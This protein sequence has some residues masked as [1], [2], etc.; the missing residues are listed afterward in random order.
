M[1]AP[2]CEKRIIHYKIYKYFNESLFL[3]DLQH[4]IFQVA[5]IVDN[6]DDQFWFYH[7]LWESVIDSNA[8][9][10]KH[11]IKAKQLPL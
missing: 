8:P 11:V 5:K 10:K 2:K 6:P 9:R 3:D 1:Y 4:T 7:K